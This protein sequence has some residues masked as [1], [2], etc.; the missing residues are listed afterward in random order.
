MAD[1]TWLDNS[2]DASWLDSA[3]DANPT[4]AN[5]T[6]LAKYLKKTAAAKAA[7]MAPDNRSWGQKIED[8]GRSFLGIPGTPFGEL[9]RAAAAGLNSLAPGKT[10]RQERE[11]IA[12]DEGLSADP[13]VRKAQEQQLFEESIPYMGIVSPSLGG[14][15]V[16]PRMFPKTAQVLEDAGNRSI[17]RGISPTEKDTAFIRSR[18]STPGGDVAADAGR[19]LAE[20][21]VPSTGEQVIPAVGAPRLRN[22]RNKQVI[23]ETGNAIK[24]LMKDLEAKGVA[25]ID[26]D[27]IVAK[28]K[29]MAAAMDTPAARVVSNAADAKKAAAL[30]DRLANEHASG[31]VPVASEIEYQAPPQGEL[32]LPQD[33][34]TRYPGE[35]L[36]SNRKPPSV[37]DEFPSWGGAGG[38]HVQIPEIQE[39]VSRQPT[40]D[41]GT[42]RG[43]FTGTLFPEQPPGTGGVPGS[44]INTGTAV[45]FMGRMS[46]QELHNL[47][48]TLDDEVWRSASQRY[49]T[50]TKEMAARDPEYRFKM[51]LAGLAAEELDR[52]VGRAFGPEAVSRYQTLRKQFG[53]AK[54]FDPLIESIANREAAGMEH[55]RRL[56]MAAH[57][58]LPVAGAA[59][60]AV[61][62]G[63][64]G[65]VLGGLLGSVAE[66]GRVAAERNLS[67]MPGRAMLR[68]A[69]VVGGEMPLMS[70]V[71]QS[72]ENQMLARY[73]A[74]ELLRKKENSSA[75]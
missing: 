48:V 30:A 1:T 70:T 59:S 20:M 65:A 6:I 4:P 64:S 31:Y 23:E 25:V 34:T 47:M 36:V 46:P 51:G 2:P 58:T 11:R 53:A 18:H 10:Y 13:E 12:A 22:A 67:S 35:V 38:R 14:P 57:F 9:T 49:P 56:P 54:D 39:G 61:G 3:P 68:L 7:A 42:Q 44:P 19:V 69:P 71:G 63:A 62:G 29:D 26:A 5:E 45:K 72:A 50:K 33:V 27:P 21:R 17:F 37:N 52:A 40:M 41:F 75:P 73:I 16:G 74:E 55:K 43:S 15:R 24:A 66:L 60:G 28:A 8:F 32:G